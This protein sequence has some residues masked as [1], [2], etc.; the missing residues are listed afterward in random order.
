M[1][2][3]PPSGS[4]NSINYLLE[5]FALGNNVEHPQDRILCLDVGDTWAC[6]KDP[7]SNARRAF[8]TLVLRVRQDVSVF[9]M[10]HVSEELKF[11]SIPYKRE[12][13]LGYTYERP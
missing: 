1:F 5:K 6:L 12:K 7:F 8:F 9:S 4:S 13:A 3:F 11:S 10:D 2:F